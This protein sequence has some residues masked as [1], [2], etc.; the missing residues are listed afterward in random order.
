MSRK[1]AILTLIV[2]T[3]LVGACAQQE[4]A[5]DPVEAAYSAVNAAVAEANSAEETTTLVEDFLARFPDTEHSGW[6]ATMI[7][8]YRADTMKDPEGTYEVLS[9]ALER[10][11]SPKARFDV[12]MQMLALS[13]SVEVPLEVGEVASVLSAARAL[14]FAE[15]EQVAVNATASE[16]WALAQQHASAAF[17]L[18]TPEAFSAE[19]GKW[20]LT[21]DELAMWLQHFKAFYL[22]HEGWAAYNQGDTELAFT[23]FAESDAIGSESY[24]G[25]PTTPLYTFW[26]RAALAEG[27]VD[28][29]FELLGAQTLFGEDGSGAEPFLREA[30]VA[31]NGDDEGF[32]EFLWSTRNNLAAAVDDFEL[33]DYDGNPVSLS[34][35]GDGKVVLLSFWFPT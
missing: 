30:Y 35:V 14:T 9:A 15:H 17:E 26:G 25:V 3:G 19:Y 33:A 6:A 16:E 5:T 1:T 22:A 12:S 31:E 23:R 20:G 21:D 11:E 29:A 4:E 24:L 10:I 34:K 7:V 32:D 2:L 28:R 13:D 18:A 27:D 8:H